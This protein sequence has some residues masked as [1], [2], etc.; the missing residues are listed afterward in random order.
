MVCF[1]FRAV[2]GKAVGAWGVRWRINVALR[3]GVTAAGW[4]GVADSIRSFGV[5]GALIGGGADSWEPS[6]SN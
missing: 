4:R 6:L 3:R 5:A 1:G 2:R